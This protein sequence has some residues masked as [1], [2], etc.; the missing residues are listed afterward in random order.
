MYL[1]TKCHMCKCG[2]SSLIAIKPKAEENIRTA[3]MLLFYL[4]GHFPTDATEGSA[5]VGID[6]A[7]GQIYGRVGLKSKRQHTGNWSAAA[8]PPGRVIAQQYSPTTSASFCFHSRKK[9]CER[10]SKFYFIFYSFWNYVNRR[11]CFVKKQIN[12]SLY[13]GEV[14]YLTSLHYPK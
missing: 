9:K 12:Q 3:A 2:E 1:Y 5:Q 6:C 4:N 8:W 7:Y 10:V 13:F 11:F 14:W